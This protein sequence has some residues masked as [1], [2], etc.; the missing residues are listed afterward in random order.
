MAPA[1]ASERRRLWLLGVI[2]LIPFLSLAA[3]ARVGS[4]APWEP[5]L[6]DAA[7]LSADTW[8]QLVRAVSR[9]GDLV[10]W[11]LLLTALGVTLLVLR[12]VAA[13]VLTAATLASDLAAAVTKVF[14][15]RMRPEA[16]LLEGF[17]GFDSFAYPSGHVVRAVSLAAVLAWLLLP[18]RWRLGGALAAALVA[19][20][21]MGYS[22]VA[23][24]V[25]WPTDVLGGLLLGI[26][27]F[28]GTAYLFTRHRQP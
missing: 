19:G 15:E 11:T 26:A 6:L 28:S 18:E 10:P 14:V 13:A 2:A 25:H 12:G 9:L 17:A 22:R 20:A 21:L 5:A 8:A 27:W 1:G 23:L 4:P 24:G 7:A 3:W 16:A